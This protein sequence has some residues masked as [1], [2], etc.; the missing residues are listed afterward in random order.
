MAMSVVRSHGVGLH[1][2]SANLSDYS[3]LVRS[4]AKMVAGLTRVSVSARTVRK[5][6]VDWTAMSASEMRPDACMDQSWLRTRANALVLTVA[7][8]AVGRAHI[9]R[10]VVG[11]V[12]MGER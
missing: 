7:T 3:V 1:A 11:H 4:S 6:G 5:A 10:H 8:L 2:I 9:R 12:P